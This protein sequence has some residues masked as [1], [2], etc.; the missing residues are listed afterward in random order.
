[1]PSL[2]DPSLT[3]KTIILAFDGTANKF[4]PHNTNIIRLFSLFE[5]RKP[6]EQVLYYQPGIGTYLA[7]GAAWSPTM[8][9][10]MEMLDSVFAWYLDIHIMDGYRFLM[11]HYNEG[12]TVCMFG[13]SRG[14]YTARCLAGMLN[15]AS[16][17][18]TS[19]V[20]SMEF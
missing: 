14:A 15:K 17:E 12:D 4:C 7:E 8:K 20:V 19:P 2:P 18:G 11:K 5:K 16:R 3:P 10:M 1:M 13:F 6:N 9:G